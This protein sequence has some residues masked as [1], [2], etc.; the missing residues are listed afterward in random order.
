ML[1]GSLFWIFVLTFISSALPAD[2]ICTNVAALAQALTNPKKV[3]PHNFDFTGT[4]TCRLTITPDKS[5]IALFD[6]SGSIRVLDQRAKDDVQPGDVIHVRGAIFTAGRSYTKTYPYVTELERIG[7]IKPPEPIE[8]TIGEIHKGKSSW[9]LLRVQGLVRDIQV[10]PEWAVLDLCSSEGSLYVSLPSVV[11]PKEQMKELIG[12]N[13]AIDGF[14][15]P[16]TGANHIFAGVHFQCPGISAIH[17]LD[18]NAPDPFNAPS[19]E[20]LINRLPGEIAVMGY[21]KAHGQVLCTWDKAN[22]LMRMGNDNIVHLCFDEGPLPPVE[23]FIEATGL[24]QSDLSHITLVH[25]KWRPA[26]SVYLH[27]RDVRETS[28]AAVLTDG[29]GHSHSLVHYHGRSIRLTGLVRAPSNRP[30]HKDTFF[31]DDDGTLIPINISSIPET[32]SDIPEGSTV[33]VTGVCVMEAEYW[34]PGL[35]IPQV[36]GFSVVVTKPSNI[37]ILARPS[38]WTS[39]R[40]LAVIGMLLATL[41]GILVW[42][43]ALRRLAARKGRELMREQLGHIKA[44]LKTAERTRLAVEL[45]D[46]LAQNLT[47]VSME[48]EA[49]SDLRGKAPKPMLDHLEIAGKA[50]KSCRDELRNCLWDL[51]SQALE[52]QDMT[53]AVLKT[54]QPHINDSRLAVRFNLPR[55]RLS[56]NTTH[57]L[58]RVIRELVI[59]AIRHGNASSIKVAGTL[60]GQ[61]LLCSVSDNGCG[62]NPERSPGVLQGHFGLQ[63][64]RERIDEIGGTFIIDSALGKGTRATITI[65][66]PHSDKAAVAAIEDHV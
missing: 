33:Q 14:P 26:S 12:R 13:V 38:W 50:L 66:I 24:P 64:I 40:L 1:R 47:G 4:V 20:T 57:A 31:L 46:T 59:N 51:R 55:A 18:L 65:A 29:K 48:I 63:G 22:A 42:N 58:L 52:E 36:R 49:A 44:Q 6:S 30:N 16:L 11:A 62:F 25:T 5:Y 39:G 27:P 21:V 61:T 45:H 28:A 3:I 34:H 10:A 41:V 8:S 19:A 7:Q 9:R 35:S 15:D 60:D 32:E 53:K 2:T 54:L 43:A 37:V 23:S 17:P 56:D